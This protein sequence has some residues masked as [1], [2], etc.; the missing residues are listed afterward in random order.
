MPEQTELP[1]SGG[2]AVV[3]DRVDMEGVATGLAGGGADALTRP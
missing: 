2:P 1:I 3:P